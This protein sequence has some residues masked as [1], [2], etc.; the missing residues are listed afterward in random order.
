MGQPEDCSRVVVVT[1]TSVGQ[2][3]SVCNKQ[4][5]K[6]GVKGDAARDTDTRGVTIYL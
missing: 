2:Q 4:H 3:Y 5:G 6:R 1:L